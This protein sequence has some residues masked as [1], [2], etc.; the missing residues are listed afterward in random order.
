MLRSESREKRLGS[1]SRM[2]LLTTWQL[3]I[4]SVSRLRDAD[5]NRARIA[6]EDTLEWLPHQEMSKHSNCET[7]PFKLARQE[8][9]TRW[10]MV[11][12]QTKR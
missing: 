5:S 4:L 3:D 1:L 9:S 8:S 6:A 11:F 7:L 12:R 2:E 10:K